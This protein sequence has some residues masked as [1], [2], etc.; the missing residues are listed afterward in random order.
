MVGVGGGGGGAKNQCWHCGLCSKWWGG[1][2]GGL[3]AKNHALVFL[4]TL[5]RLQHCSRIIGTVVGNIILLY[6]M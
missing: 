6:Y 2:G 4:G 1:G 5:K 3:G